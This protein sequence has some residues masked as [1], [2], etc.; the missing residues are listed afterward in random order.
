VKPIKT[1]CYLRSRALLGL[2]GVHSLGVCQ[3]NYFGEMAVSVCISL[4]TNA[5]QSG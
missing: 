2:T 1:R 4:K 5:P 3:G